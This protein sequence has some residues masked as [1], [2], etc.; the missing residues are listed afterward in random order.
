MVHYVGHV[1]VLLVRNPTQQIQDIF[2]CIVQLS[3]PEDLL[4]AGR[5]IDIGQVLGDARGRLDCE[6]VRHA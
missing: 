4:L 3:R 2:L 5:E 6:M 1:G